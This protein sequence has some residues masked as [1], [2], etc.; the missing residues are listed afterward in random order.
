LCSIAYILHCSGDCQPET[1]V[2]CRLMIQ[3]AFMRNVVS[4]PKG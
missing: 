4:F 2:L 1:D 3:L